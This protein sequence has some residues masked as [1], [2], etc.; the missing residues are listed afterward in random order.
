MIRVGDNFG[1]KNENC[2]L[3]LIEKNNQ[4][5]IIDCVVIKFQC[6]EVF[7]NTESVYTDIFSKDIEKIKSI[8][9]LIDIALRKRDQLLLN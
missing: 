5:H 8:I 7:N 2:P 3:C 9:S 4:S 6:S 1:N